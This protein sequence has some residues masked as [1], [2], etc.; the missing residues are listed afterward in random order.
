MTKI[1]HSVR[2]KYIFMFHVVLRL[3]N[4]HLLKVSKFP[5]TDDFGRENIFPRTAGNPMYRLLPPERT[6]NILFPP[7]QLGVVDSATSW[8]PHTLHCIAAYKLVGETEN[9]YALL[10]SF[11]TV[12]YALPPTQL[13]PWG[14]KLKY[15]WN[16]RIVPFRLKWLL[17][18]KCL[19]HS[20]E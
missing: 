20:L 2:K 5:R 9:Y 12:W 17:L 3:S 4:F 19:K 7:F 1:P 18:G 13:L 6:R 16:C 14:I 15:V 10:L 11:L 8:S